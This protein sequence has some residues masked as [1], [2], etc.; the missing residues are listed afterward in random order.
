MPEHS[1]IWRLN[2]FLFLSEKLGN[3]R[4]GQLDAYR[5]KG[6]LFVLDMFHKLLD[7]WND[8]TKSSVFY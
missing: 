6:I 1:A 8:I 3:R 2:S 7:S 5:I 4:V